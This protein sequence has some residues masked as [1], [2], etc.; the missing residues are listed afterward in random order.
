MLKGKLFFSDD[1]YAFLSEHSDSFFTNNQTI[2][3]VRKDDGTLLEGQF[4]EYLLNTACNLNVLKDLFSDEKNDTTK[5]RI[6]NKGLLQ[7]TQ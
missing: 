3:Q 7:I 4:A 6:N 2:M 1:S 5:P